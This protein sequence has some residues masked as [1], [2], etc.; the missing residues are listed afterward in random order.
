MDLQQIR[1]A[2]VKRLIEERCN[3]SQAQFAGKISRSSAYVHQLISTKPSSRSVGEKTARHIEEKLGLSRGELD[4]APHQR[5]AIQQ[6]LEL[7]TLEE[8]DKAL[9]LELFECLTKAQ[10]DD[11]IKDLRAAVESNKVIVREVGGR[12]SHPTDKKVAQ[13]LPAAP[14]PDR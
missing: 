7:H 4:L 12:L 10:R 14:K 3:G 13:I 11:A 2:N 5:E 6:S 1:K 9:I 8:K